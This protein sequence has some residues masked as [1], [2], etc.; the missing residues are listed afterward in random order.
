MEYLDLAVNPQRLEQLVDQYNELFNEHP[1]IARGRIFLRL[2]LYPI[3]FRNL[4]NI[5]RKWTIDLRPN[6]YELRLTQL[7]NLNQILQRIRNL[8]NQINSDEV[9]NSVSIFLRQKVLNLRR[10][11]EL[12][13]NDQHNNDL[14]QQWNL[15]FDNINYFIQLPQNQPI[16]EN[17]DIDNDNEIMGDDNIN[18][19]NDNVNDNEHINQFNNDLDQYILNGRD[20]QLFFQ[21]LI[22]S[23]DDPVRLVNGLAMRFLLVNQDLTADN[24]IL[25]LFTYYRRLLDA[26]TFYW[27]ISRQPDNYSQ[28][29]FYNEIMLRLVHSL[30]TLEIT[31]H[32]FWLHLEYLNEEGNDS[33]TSYKIEPYRIEPLLITLSALFNGQDRTRDQIKQAGGSDIAYDFGQ[34]LFH[35]TRLTFCSFNIDFMNRHRLDFPSQPPINYLYGFY[36]NNI[37]YRN[38]TGY[39][40]KGLNRNKRQYNT[41]QRR[42]EVLR[43]SGIPPSQAFMQR[44][45]LD[46]LYMLYHD[47]YRHLDRGGFFNYFNLINYYDLT[48]YQI[49]NTPEDFEKYKN[50]Y[51]YNCFLWALK[52][53]K[54]LEDYELEEIGS[55]QLIRVLTLAKMQNFLTDQ[56]IE[57]TLK[58]PKKTYINYKLGLDQD[59]D[60][61]DYPHHI[62][63]KYKW[64]ISHYGK[65]K[66][67]INMCLIEKHL[68]LDEPIP[69]SKMS[70]KNNEEIINY[71]K[72][73][74]QSINIK[75]S[76]NRE[77]EKWLKLHTVREIIRDPL[78]GEIKYLKY[79]NITK[80]PYSSWKSSDLILS[81]YIDYLKQKPNILLKMKYMDLACLDAGYYSNTS[82][83]IRNINLVKELINNETP[84]EEIQKREWKTLLYNHE[85]TIRLLEDPLKPSKEAKKN[86][87]NKT[88]KNINYYKKNHYDIKKDY[89]IYYADFEACTSDING[90]LLKEGHIPFMCCLRESNTE[91][92]FTFIGKEC[93]KELLDFLIQDSDP[94]KYDILVY[95]HNLSYDLNF[96]MKYGI[97]DCVPRNSLI[98]RSTIS[99]NNRNITFKDSF[100]LLS[101]SLETIAKSFKLPIEKEIMPYNYYS[102]E[103]IFDGNGKGNINNIL[104]IEHHWNNDKLKEFK[105]K[106]IEM[107]EDPYN[108]DMMKYCEYYCQRDVDVLCQAMDLFYEQIKTS[109]ELDIHKIIS[110]S[111]VADKYLRKHV[112][113]PFNNLYTYSNHIRDFLLEAVHGGRV[114]CAQNRRHHYKANSRKEGLWD[115]D[116]VSL[117]PSAMSCLYIVGGDPRAL[118]Y[119]E[120]D[121]N[122]LQEKFIEEEITAYVVEIWI[123]GINKKKDFPLPTNK[124]L[125]TGKITNTNIPPLRMVVCD[126]ELQD[127]V[128]FQHIEF[129]IIRG[130]VWERSRGSTKDYSIQEVIKDLF[131]KRAHY[132]KEKNP[133]EQAYKLL[134]NSIYGKTIQ[135]AVEKEITFKHASDLNTQKWI[136]QHSQWIDTIDS[137]KDSD[138]LK[139]KSFRAINKHFNNT[140][141]GVHILAMSKRL[142]NQVMCLAD[143]LN[144][145]IYYQDTDSMHIR[146]DQVPL[147][148]EKFYEKYHRELRGTNLTQFHPDFNP[149][150]EG[151]S[152]PDEVVAIESYFLGKKCYID[153]LEDQEGNRSYHVRMKGISNAAIKYKAEEEE[154]CTLMD[155]YRRMYDGQTI[156][157]DLCAAGVKF[158]NNKNGIVKSLEKFERKVRATLPFSLDGIDKLHIGSNDNNDHDNNDHDNSEEEINSLIEI[159][160][161][162][163]E[164]ES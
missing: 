9:R 14:Y 99:Y 40:L 74:K 33:V 36:R 104:K 73:K 82:K 23:Y 39:S 20:P 95:F 53:S 118:H 102:P 27:S 51:C 86:Y 103:L 81:M 5:M 4:L 78:N 22:A 68:F 60:D 139:I 153:L 145:D 38:Y 69:L 149:P 31:D 16:I 122:Y 62:N 12:I 107:N 114:M 6:Y 35:A 148:E 32:I 89:K 76:Y 66:R 37:Y 138:I 125:K 52:Q 150:K 28:I 100:A 11:R 152:I 117:Y 63:K 93:G 85:N 61:Q 72:K 147:L 8:L 133:L 135:K 106:L 126:I 83:N 43:R 132:K 129:H 141:L 29:L 91:R 30:T 49:P 142:M 45:N 98:L 137:I 88:K 113:Y 64:K 41:N 13:H 116:A 26:N 46:R 96:I 101:F 156:K 110:I 120:L 115:I 163:C 162:E 140:L 17:N 108:F 57:I 143:D 42:I 164:S 25:L 158:N 84:I 71:L 48:R 121:Y 3:E 67:K 65:G 1:N 97:T 7:T 94:D 161:N 58:K 80:Q 134:L 59:N 55:S 44:M 123:T 19:N 130:L 154:D 77:N 109:F 18:D 131:K 34:H 21:N 56:N 24:W 146:K 2:N 79:R 155:L 119:D 136:I 90:K 75:L 92:K 87:Y 128:E 124:D 70:Y 157:F 54:L 151:I 159:L 105:D 160:L 47:D 127:L 144:I 111:S 50:I 15:L 112:Y 10:L